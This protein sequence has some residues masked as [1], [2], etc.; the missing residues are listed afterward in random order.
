[1]VRYLNPADPNR[2][3]ITKAD[4]DFPHRLDFRDI[5]L[6]VKTRDIL[7]IGKKN[8]V[9]ISVFDYENKVRY[10]IY[11]S[12]K[13]YEG[14]HVDLLLIVEGEKKGYLLIEDFNTFMCDHT[15]HRGRK[16]FC[17]YCFQVFSSEEILKSHIKDCFKNNG[18]QTIKMSQNGE[19]NKFKNSG[20]KLNHHLWFIL[21]LK[22]FKYL[23]IKEN[24]ILMILKLTN[25]KN[26][27]LVV[28][29]IN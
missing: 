16:H 3:R 24:K 23:K 4:K 18:K 5:K 9:S 27:L 22:V 8:S 14:K 15:L 13:C 26:M 29:V 21:N 25:V 20:K 19:Y 28:M 7:K 17:R 2:T 1:M 6:P 10:P 12:K 11:A